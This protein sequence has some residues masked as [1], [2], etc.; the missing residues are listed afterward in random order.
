MIK[1]SF[2]YTLTT[3]LA[4]KH[5]RKYKIHFLGSNDKHTIIYQW[6]SSVIFLKETTAIITFFFKVF[7]QQ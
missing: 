4:I 3:I 1:P 7:D 2:K 5:H 6:K